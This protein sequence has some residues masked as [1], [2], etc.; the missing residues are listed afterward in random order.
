MDFQSLAEGILLWQH[1]VI[2]LIAVYVVVLYRPHE[3]RQL[4]EVSIFISP[5]EQ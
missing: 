2:E 3:L 5:P 1:C 4:L